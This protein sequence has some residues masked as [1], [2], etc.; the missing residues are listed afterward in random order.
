MS[1]QPIHEEDPQDP[2]VILRDLPERERPVFLRQYQDAVDAAHNPA[3][4]K[5]LQRLLHAWSVKVIAVNTPG[6]YEAI[7]EAKNGEGETYPFDEALAAAL[8]RQP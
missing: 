5:R 2:Q 6:Y 8:A 7:D 3:G 1:A 4:Y